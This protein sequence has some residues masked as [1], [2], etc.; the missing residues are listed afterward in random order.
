MAKNP[1]DNFCRYPK[2]ATAYNSTPYSVISL[3]PYQFKPSTNFSIKITLT[4]YCQLRFISKS[5][6]KTFMKKSGWPSLNVAVI[7]L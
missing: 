6:A 3:R 5:M 2:N 4:A 1:D 7:S